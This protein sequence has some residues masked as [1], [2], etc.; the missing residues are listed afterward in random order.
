MADAGVTP[1]FSAKGVVDVAASQDHF[2]AIVQEK[3]ICQKPPTS[4]GDGNLT[5]PQAAL[6]FQQLD[7]AKDS[8]RACA[9]TVGGEVVCWGK[10]SDGPVSVQLPKEKFYVKVQVSSSYACALDNTAALLCAPFAGS[11]A[12]AIPDVV[13]PRDVAEFAIGGAEYDDTNFICLRKRDGDTACFGKEVPSLPPGLKSTQILVQAE[14]RQLCAL[15]PAA[16]V[17]CFAPKG[18]VRWSFYDKLVGVEKMFNSSLGSGIG[19]FQAGVPSV[20]SDYWSDHYSKG[21]RIPLFDGHKNS[22]KIVMGAGF[23]C[24]LDTFRN[25]ECIPAPT[26][27]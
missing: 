26:E 13:N 20:W 22:Q 16:T 4:D 17:R 27:H 21:A 5:P 3:I 15:T 11:D 12:N 7:I 1:D 24:V 19:V 10:D 25:L 23:A 9:V 2:C 6:P 14:F 18:E 8:S